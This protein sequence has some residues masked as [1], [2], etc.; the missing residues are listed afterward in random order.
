MDSKEMKGVGLL[1]PVKIGLLLDTA[2]TA[3]FW[4]GLKGLPEFL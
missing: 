1:G 2:D 4:A 3:H